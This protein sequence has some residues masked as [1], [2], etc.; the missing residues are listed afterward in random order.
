MHIEIDQDRCCASGQC[1]LTAEDVFTQ[2]D[3]DGVV[4][5]VDPV[6]SSAAAQERAVEAAVLCP[7]GAISVHLRE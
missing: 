5:L 7:A 4:A 1:V 6:P 2:R 3:E